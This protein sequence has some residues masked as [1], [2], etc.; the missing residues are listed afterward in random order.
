MNLPC[1]GSHFADFAF[2]IKD[3]GQ[4]I[5]FDPQFKTDT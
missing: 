1:G 3:Q 2:A 5:I 4:H